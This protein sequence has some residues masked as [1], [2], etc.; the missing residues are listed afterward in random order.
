MMR[1]LAV[2]LITTASA[3]GSSTRL[4]SGALEQPTSGWDM[5][6]RGWNL[7]SQAVEPTEIQSPA[8]MEEEEETTQEVPDSQPSLSVA[9]DDPLSDIALPQ[10]APKLKVAPAA[11]AAPPVAPAVAP[12]PVVSIPAVEA[13][14]K[15]QLALLEELAVTP[16]YKAPEP[17]LPVAKAR[18]NA[19]STPMLRN[20][21]NLTKGTTHFVDG[22]A[23][24][25]PTIY[26][27]DEHKQ[28]NPPCKAHRG[29]CNDRVCFCKTPYT[30]TTCQNEISAGSY[31][32]GPTLVVGCSVVALGLGIFM[33]M[34]I[35]SFIRENIEKRMVSLG[36]ETVNKESWTPSDTGTKKKIR[37]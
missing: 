34:I 4:R 28:C 37:K 20:D 21:R 10:A 1:F 15:Q 25:D 30:G 7:E 3:A 36:D 33:A 5:P 2:T 6:N 19:V 35:Y 14:Q 31:R 17:K 24:K 23:P 32:F 18:G 22:E 13:S 27:L 11:A 9:L 26:A 29:V 8:E 16:V 12:P